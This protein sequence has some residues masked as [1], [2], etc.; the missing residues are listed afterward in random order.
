M[1]VSN[2]RTRTFGHLAARLCTAL[3]LTIGVTGGIF[4]VI[5]SAGTL[6]VTEGNMNAG[7]SGGCDA[8]QPGG[9]TYWFNITKNCP[10]AGMSVDT[11]WS[12][13]GGK[14]AFWMT[15][16]PAGITI[17]SAWTENGDVQTSNLANGFVVGDFWIDNG[18][19]Q[20]GGS[21]LASGQHWLNTTL[22]G[23]QNI[24]SG[25]YGIQMVCTHSGGS[26]DGQ[27]YPTF[28]VNGIE[29]QATEN[30]GPAIVAEGSNNLWYQGGQYVRGSGWP[31]SF[32][33]SDP[34]GVCQMHALINGQKIL[35]PSSSP[36]HTVW[37][38]C[39]DQNWSQ[40]I[41]T[42]SYIPAS[43][44]LPLTLEATNAAG[45]DGQPSETLRVDNEPV[46]LSLSGPTTA[47]TVAGT[48]HLL[49]SAT[50]GP[51]GVWIGCSVDGGPEQ[52][53]NTGSE[54]IPVSGAG[55][56]T[57]SCRARNGAID[58]HG[59][60]AYSPTQTWSINIGQPTVSAI[61]FQ[62]L[63]DALKC[64]RAR[65]RVTLP[66]RWVKVRR[67]HKLVRVHKRARTTTRTV[68]RCHPRVVWQ[69][70]KVWVKI[71]RHGKLVSV[72]RIRRVRVPLV[73]HAVTKAS[74][75]VVF[76]HSTTVSGW[77]GTATGVAIG[78][79]PVQVLAAADNGQGRFRVAATVTTAA[80]GSWSAKLGPGPSR[81]VEAA[82]AGSTGLLPVTSTPAKLRVPA[83]I[84]LHPGPRILPWNRTVTLRG[85]LVGGYV[86][87]DGVALRLLIDVPHRAQPYE[88]VPFRTNAN[89][90][91]AVRWSWGR[92]SGVASFPFAVATT[93]TESDYPYSA[94]RSPWVRVTFGRPTPRRR[95]HHHRGR[96]HKQGHTTS[97]R[98]GR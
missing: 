28:T 38:Q 11:N 71:R 97:A 15:T 20:Y 29:L 25:I 94:S 21:T 86:P 90:Q 3:I 75:R 42:R 53:Q 59:D 13:P 23:T 49:A 50:A 72:P 24:N 58:P 74:K 43:G 56:H 77:L 17:N 96:R 51:S 37:H 69:R 61:G 83:R 85:H 67:H 62:K 76:G 78:G 93:A 27:A 63:V 92:G 39:P 26:C 48:Q 66:A 70:K 54:Q 73:P 40:T 14:N 65:E 52:W 64:H 36:D 4:P 68:Q 18:T 34:S 87:P 46:Q 6:Y 81:L 88:P 2:S 55:A 16:A 41:D 47:S 79:A 84:T 35:G 7:G 12:P 33:A 32:S 10:G 5:A 57:A 89:G 80:N 8:F 30:Q 95:R 60:Y 44:Q 19:G 1:P 9:S 22:E 82:Y 45:V 98:L 31:I 91:F